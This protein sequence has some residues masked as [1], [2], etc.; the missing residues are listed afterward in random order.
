M[1]LIKID[2][3]PMEPDEIDHQIDKMMII[4]SYD[5]L[6]TD[7]EGQLVIYTG[8]YRWTDGT[9]RRMPDPSIT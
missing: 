4:D 3:R 6:E 8:V 9:Y 5:D 1:K 2:D 7:F